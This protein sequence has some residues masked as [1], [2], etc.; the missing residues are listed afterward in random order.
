MIDLSSKHLSQAFE[1]GK[2]A[3]LPPSNVA[4]SS[5]PPT[6]ARRWEGGLVRRI[7]VQSPYGL[8]IVCLLLSS[9][10]LINQ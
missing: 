3:V 9:Q 5:L 7:Q 4:D 6:P 10:C 1:Q 2:G 8:K